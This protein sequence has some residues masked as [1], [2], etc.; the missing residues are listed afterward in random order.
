MGAFDLAGVAGDRGCEEFIDEGAAGDS[1]WPRLPLCSGATAHFP[2]ARAR[3]NAAISKAMLDWQ[4][5]GESTRVI[6]AAS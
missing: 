1:G 6:M 3:S 5:G 4:S 2:L